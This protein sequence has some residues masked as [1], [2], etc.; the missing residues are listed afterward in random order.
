M[1]CV[2]VLVLLL[3]S[4]GEVRGSAP[5][6]TLILKLSGTGHDSRVTV[7]VMVRLGTVYLRDFFSAFFL[8]LIVTG[9]HML[10]VLGQH[11]LVHVPRTSAATM[12]LIVWI[13]I[14]A[15]LILQIQTTSITS[16]YRLRTAMHWPSFH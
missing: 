15:A 11:L 1:I 5:R 13:V 2:L 6:Q 12:P 10:L 9:R 16:P 4:S 7:A 8:R 3:K 14:D